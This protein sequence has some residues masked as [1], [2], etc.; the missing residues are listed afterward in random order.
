MVY[1]SIHKYARIS[2]FKARRVAN[3]LKR[4]S[5]TDLMAYLRIM[6]HAAAKLIQKVAQSSAANALSR[7]PELDE[8]HLF[9]KNIII[10]EGPRTKRMWPRARGR[11]DILLKRMSHITVEL[12]D[13]LKNK[14]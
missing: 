6:P 4:K 14:E 11:A 9:V 10:D 12:E 13:N 8:S 7:N 1:K 3:T 2:P 5:Y